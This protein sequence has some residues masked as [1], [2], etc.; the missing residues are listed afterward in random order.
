MGLASDCLLP[1]RLTKR[2][3][4]LPLLIPSHFSDGLHIVI[5]GSDT[6]SN[7]ESNL[8]GLA[9]N[10]VQK[11]CL[12]HRVVSLTTVSNTSYKEA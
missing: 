2:S 7:V 1:A 5:Q 12:A 11:S 3:S 9:N 10:L 4:V 8:F 6:A